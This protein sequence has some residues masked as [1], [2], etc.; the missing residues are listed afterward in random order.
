MVLGM[1]QS[2]R[3]TALYCYYRNFTQSGSYP[4]WQIIRTYAHQGR[5]ILLCVCVCVCVCV[6]AC[7]C[8]CVKG[9]I[10]VEVEAEWALL[11]APVA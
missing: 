5:S 4:L 1:C 2:M 8:V 7:V 3:W 6:C 11:E 10:D 9:T